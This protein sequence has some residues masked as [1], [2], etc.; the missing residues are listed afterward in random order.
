MPKR[1]HIPWDCVPIDFSN[2]YV[3]LLQSYCVKG[4]EIAYVQLVHPRKQ[5]CEMCYVLKKMVSRTLSC[6]ARRDT[7]FRQNLFGMTIDRKKCCCDCGKTLM[8]IGHAHECENV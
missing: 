1:F 3:L 8:I 7:R 5:L 4:T 6:C 2:K